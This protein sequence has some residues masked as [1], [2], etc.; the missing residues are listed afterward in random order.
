[1]AKSQESSSGSS[2]PSNLLMTSSSKLQPHHLRKSLQ[3]ALCISPLA[4]LIPVSM[5]KRLFS[6]LSACKLWMAL[7]NKKP[8][9]LVAVERK[10]WQFIFKYATVNE[11]ILPPLTTLLNELEILAKAASPEDLAWFT[12]G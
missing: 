4:A 7:G 9:T 3:V 1:V 10:M 2:F 12:A 6:D 8:P 5:E 11:P